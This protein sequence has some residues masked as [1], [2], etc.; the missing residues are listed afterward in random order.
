[1]RAQAV[2]EQRVTFLSV[3]NCLHA[4]DREFVKKDTTIGVQGSARFKEKSSRNGVSLFS[5]QSQAKIRLSKQCVLVFNSVE[6]CR[7]TTR[8]GCKQADK[9][10]EGIQ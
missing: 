9:E 7:P 2:Q 6:K 8:A 10:D 3:T 4:R 1:M 5:P